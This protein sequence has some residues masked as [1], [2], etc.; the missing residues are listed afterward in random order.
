MYLSKLGKLQNKSISTIFGSSLKDDIS[1][2]CKIL[3]ILTLLQIIKF[4]TTKFVYKYINKQL[5]TIF[6]SY[7][8]LASS[9]HSHNIRFS[10]QQNLHIPLYKTKRTQSLSKFTRTK[11]WNS[12]SRLETAHFIN[13]EKNLKHI[14]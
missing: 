2:Q 12:I 10:N 6:D 4:K 13:S 3:E 8:V 9:T 11:I 5:P 7:F 1:S 14:F